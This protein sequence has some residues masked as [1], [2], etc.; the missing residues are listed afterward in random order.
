MANSA[1]SPVL[2]VIHT[3]SSGISALKMRII[4]EASRVAFFFFFFFFSPPPLPLSSFFF[5]FLEQE[6]EWVSHR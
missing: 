2:V 1:Y 3:S 4:I 6:E 5:F